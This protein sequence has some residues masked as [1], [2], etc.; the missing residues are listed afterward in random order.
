MESHSTPKQLQT[1]EYT[2]RLNRMRTL[3]EVQ[4]EGQEKVSISE[5]SVLLFKPQICI[6]DV[7]A[8]AI[9]PED[10]IGQHSADV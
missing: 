1:G 9:R 8:A 5:I 4:S 7:K 10:V 2:I 3:G 6:P